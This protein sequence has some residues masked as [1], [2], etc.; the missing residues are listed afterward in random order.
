MEKL[1]KMTELTG[2]VVLP[3]N[4]HLWRV[5][6]EMIGQRFDKRN[7]V[8]RTERLGD[9]EPLEAVAVLG[10]VPHHVQH[11]VHQLRA[12]GVVALEKLLS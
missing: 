6:V 3:R 8:V 1:G 11:G 9:L 10:L 5:A 4:E 12:V 7:H 2:K